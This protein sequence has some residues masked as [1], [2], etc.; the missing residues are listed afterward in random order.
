MIHPNGT[1]RRTPGTETHFI[2]L[3]QL[4]LKRRIEQVNR[5]ARAASINPLFVSST[6]PLPRPHAN[7]A[8]KEFNREI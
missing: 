7:D 3:K 1:R 4:V 5:T 2:L 6:L 8:M